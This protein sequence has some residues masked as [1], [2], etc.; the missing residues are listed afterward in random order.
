M[1]RNAQNRNEFISGCDSRLIVNT[2][3]AE[4]LTIWH[5]AVIRPTSLADSVAYMVDNLWVFL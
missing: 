1:T 5:A 3:S 2:P 4:T